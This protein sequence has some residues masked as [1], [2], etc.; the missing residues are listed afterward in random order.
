MRRALMKR[1]V[2]KR[3]LIYA[4]YLFASA[5]AIM[6]RSKSV[7]AYTIYPAVMTALFGV[8]PNVVI[9]TIKKKSL[10]QT[11][12]QNSFLVLYMLNFFRDLL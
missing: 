12:H 5:S 1:Y 6:S 8:L 10:R 3:R 4:G 11:V 7:I 2:A 9:K